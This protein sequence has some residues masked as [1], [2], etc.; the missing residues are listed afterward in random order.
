MSKT[1]SGKR[2]IAIRQQVDYVTIAATGTQFL[3]DSVSA[4]GLVAMLHGNI[5]DDS[6]QSYQWQESTDGANWLS[7]IGTNSQ[8]GYQVNKSYVVKQKTYRIVVTTKA[9]KTFE[10][11]ITIANLDSMKSELQAMLDEVNEK[12][13]I[14]SVPEGKVVIEGGKIN[15]D[16]LDALALRALIISSGLITANEIDVENL[17]VK[18]LLSAVDDT[19]P[20]LLAQNGEIGF[21]RNKETE[22]NKEEA[23]VRIGI[24]VGFMGT[25]GSS[26][27]AISVRDKS[28]PVYNPQ[29]DNSY[30][31]LSSEGVFSNGSNISA[32]PAT[33]GVSS[34]F[35]IAGLLQSRISGGFGQPSI[36]AAIYGADQTSDSSASNSKGYAG[37][38]DGNVQVNGD[39][40]AGNDKGIDMTVS[41]PGYFNNQQRILQITIRKGLIVSAVWL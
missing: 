40:F 2:T 26:K 8:K 35:S 38:F 12:L 11:I 9:G 19:I 6:V 37:Y 27:P 16:M 30:S 1:V 7:A 34:A 15:A 36:N 33:S 4:I 20:R 5:T 13:G 3:G 17:V 28:H 10:A 14:D 21:F 23:L 39:L 18:R 25:N 32:I 41:V 24:D 31:E 29:G 22:A